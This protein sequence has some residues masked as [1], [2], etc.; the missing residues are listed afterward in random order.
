VVCEA[1]VRNS[2]VTLDTDEGTLLRDKQIDGFSFR[3]ATDVAPGL[4]VRVGWRGWTHRLLCSGTLGLA[5]A[6]TGIDPSPLF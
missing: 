4:K 6:S 5:W 2:E 1:S 3:V